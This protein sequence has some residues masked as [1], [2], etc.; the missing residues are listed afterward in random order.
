MPTLYDLYLTKMDQPTRGHPRW[1]HE[2]A[3]LRLI[4]QSGC[5]AR[6]DRSPRVPLRKQLQNRLLEPS[7]SCFHFASAA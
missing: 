3:P 6:A 7:I 4:N 5:L 2:I 1:L